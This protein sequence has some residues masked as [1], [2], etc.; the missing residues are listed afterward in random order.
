MK[1][2]YSAV[3]KYASQVLKNKELDGMKII[4]GGGLHSRR[5]HSVKLKCGLLFSA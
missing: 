2:Y 4:H 5:T 1:N 3:M